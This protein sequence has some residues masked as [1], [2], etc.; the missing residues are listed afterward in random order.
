MFPHSLVRSA[1]VN[2]A[3]SV[4][5][6]ARSLASHVENP[7]PSIVASV[8][9]K[10]FPYPANNLIRVRILY[11]QQAHDV[12]DD[13]QTRKVPIDESI[14]SDVEAVRTKV[15]GLDTN[16]LGASGRVLRDFTWGMNPE[17]G[18][19]SEEESR[20]TLVAEMRDIRQSLVREVNQLVAFVETRRSQNITNF[21]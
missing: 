4:L 9:Q 2:R 21:K 20:E 1:N 17:Y 3:T 11:A 10:R 7:L 5:C 16:I 6:Q 12:L 14:L 8:S 13:L 19:V 18:L 15:E